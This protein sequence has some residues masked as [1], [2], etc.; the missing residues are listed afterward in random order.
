MSSEQIQRTTYRDPTLPGSPI[1]TGDPV[2]RAIESARDMDD[3]YLPLGRVHGSSLHG[4]GIASGLK[5]TASVGSQNLNVLPGVASDAAGQHI[6]LALNGNAEIG[7]TANA[8]GAAPDL[9]GVPPS[10]AVMPTNGLSGTFYLTIQFWEWFQGYIDPNIDPNDYYKYVHTPWLRLQAT[11][12]TDGSAIVL[13]KVTLD[14]AWKV[15]SLTRDAGVGA[16]LP[17]ESIH[18]SKAVNHPSPNLS[19]DN[20]PTGKVSSHPAGGIELK[21]ENSND[22]V[23]FVRTDGSDGV[24]INAGSGILNVGATGVGGTIN[25]ID[26]ASSAVI[27]DGSYAT[28]SVGRT[29]NWGEIDVYDNNGRLA[30]ASDGQKSLVT[31]GGTNNPGVIRTFDSGRNTTIQLE[32]A[33][34]VARL[35]RLAAL[36]TDTIDVDTFKLHI[37][38][39]DLA[40]DGRSGNNNRALVDEGNQLVVNYNNDYANG[41][42]VNNLHLGDH[43]WMAYWE[44]LG[45]FNP[46]LNQWINFYTADTTLPASQWEVT[47]MCEVGM[48]AFYGHPDNAWWVTSNSSTTSATGTH[49]VRWDINYNYYQPNDGP[50]YPFSLSVFWIA[51]RI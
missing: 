19:V 15:T 27:V 20:A 29:N 5:V 16:F 30:V 14:N 26:G 32:A 25:V 31:V 39:A 13:A 47:T 9:T 45:T 8:P 33:T 28:I 42:V 10:G 7:P 6:S 17:A 40:L 46:G 43:V 24:T 49:V 44:S 51:V 11:A 3:C 21:C 37:H 18:L 4:W 50:Y 41:V 23:H 1:R 34:G 12:P 2:D 36:G 35:K 22:Q 48:V 38:G